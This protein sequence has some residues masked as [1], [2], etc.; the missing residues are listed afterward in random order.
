M[1]PL[2][3]ILHIPSLDMHKLHINYM[4]DLMLTSKFEDGGNYI[5]HSNAN[6]QGKIHETN[7]CF[8]MAILLY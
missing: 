8:N 5:K 4:N 3:S 7:M 6:G 2:F 1:L